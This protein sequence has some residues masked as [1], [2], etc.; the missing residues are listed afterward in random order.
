[1]SSA[2]IVITTRNRRDE[3]REALRSCQ[4]QTDDVD[5]LVIDDGSSDG[6]SEMVAAEFPAVRVHRSEVSRGLIVQRTAAA[7]MA[8]APVIVSIDDDAR[9]MSPRAVEQTL[10]DFD[11]PRIGAVAMPYVDVRRGGLERQRPPEPHGRW[12][13][14]TYIGT[15]H[16][17][18]RDV[19]NALGGYR[20]SFVHMV[21]EPEFCLRMLA[22]GFVVR[23]GRAPALH[24]LESP[25]QRVFGRNLRLVARNQLLDAWHNTPSRYLPG[26]VGR[27]LV[28]STF[29]SFRF[30]HPGAA[31]Q[32][33]WEALR[34]AAR[35]NDSRAP[36][37][38]DVWRL[39]VELRKR[40]PLRLEEIEARLPPAQA[41]IPS[42]SA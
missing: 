16:A 38:D 29:D 23:L 34:D 2:T 6:T 9:F 31:A 10:A 21:E 32:G 39:L 20:T 17:V 11:H 7:A 12:V 13:A 19:F 18:R 36:V 25:N 37:P 30:R 15:A 35:A 24:H 27:I 22:A 28:R 1:M 5:V 40:G 3:L 42:T 33:A 8:S 4:A 41:A 26:R 14:D